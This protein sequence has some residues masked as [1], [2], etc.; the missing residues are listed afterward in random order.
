M[1]QCSFKSILSL[2][3]LVSTPYWFNHT[4]DA[5]ETIALTVYDHILSFPSELRG[6]W[7]RG[8]GTGTV[9]YLSIRYGIILYIF[10]DTLDLIF[11]QKTLIVSIG[12]QFQPPVFN[13][14]PRGEYLRTPRKA[15]LIFR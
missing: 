10:F 4:S 13:Q 12:V 2:Q 9:L 3:G 14:E 15:S 11:I 8:V 1:L 5:I 6:I 7:K